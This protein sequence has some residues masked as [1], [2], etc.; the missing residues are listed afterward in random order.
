MGR[1][2]RCFMD[3]RF[4]IVLQPGKELFFDNG[5]IN[6]ADYMNHP[7]QRRMIADPAYPLHITNAFLK[8]FHGFAAAFDETGNIVIDEQYACVKRFFDSLGI[9]DY[10]YRVLPL[11]E[12]RDVTPVI[13]LHLPIEV[14]ALRFAV[15]EWLYNKK[16]PVLRGA[17][18][19]FVPADGYPMEP[20][21]G[22]CLYHR[23]Q[24]APA[25]IESMEDGSLA[26]CHESKYLLALAWAE[27]W[28]AIDNKIRVKICPYC[29]SVFLPPRCSPYKHSCESK[30]CK[31]QHLIASH[32]GPD[33]YK[34][35]ERER[36]LARAMLPLN[37]KRP[38][39]RPKAKDVK[40]PP[41]KG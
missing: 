2:Q 31:K 10:D 27:I 36:S 6:L 26:R 13:A 38:V 32:G 3:A 19:F 17:E 18:A 9:V 34:A 41:G 14:Q 11:Y 40:R 23:L 37:K 1:L 33:G 15:S 24:E 30:E 12:L 35:W 25:T 5:D 4:K 7:R 28:F 29:G 8:A 22:Y 21:A 20:A 16:K 39:G